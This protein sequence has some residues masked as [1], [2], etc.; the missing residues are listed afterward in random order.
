MRL[1]APLM[2]WLSPAIRFNDP[3]AFASGCSHDW[4]GALAH[5]KAVMSSGSG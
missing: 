4:V 1:I 2:Q 3:I 5:G